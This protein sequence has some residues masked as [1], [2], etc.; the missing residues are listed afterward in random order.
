MILRMNR[1]K[2][3]S[4]LRTQ[5]LKSFHPITFLRI[6]D[7][8]GLESKVRL[9]VSSI[10]AAVSLSFLI[11][12]LYTGW[13]ELQIGFQNLNY[14]MLA[15]TLLAYPLGFLPLVGI[16]HRIMC[17][18]G[19]CCNFKINLRI[20]SLSCLP[21]R[22]P[23]TIWYIST[24][25]ALYHEYQIDYSI[26]ITATALEMVWL[27]LSG[28]LLYL[29]SVL[30]GAI[31][32][33]LKLTILSITSIV[34]T[35]AVL[36]WTPFR[37]RILRWIQQRNSLRKAMIKPGDAIAILSM[38]LFA[39]SGGGTLLYI[40]SN[41]VTNIPVAQLPGLIGAWSIA[42][43]VG[44]VAGFFV[45]GLGLREA[46]LAVV[47]SNYMPLPIAAAVSILFRM[48]LA[49]GEFVWAML[50]ALLVRPKV[51]PKSY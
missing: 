14:Q 35:S 45:Q 27:S 10:I 22:I 21:K 3:L 5:K 4:F 17:C 29:L 43:T 44:L 33:N 49:V 6:F 15:I 2:R 11:Y 40:L 12:I 37:H 26:T 1:T 9:I 30:M 48:L 46:T 24:R 25:V 34:L 8:R 36:L 32:P 18:I 38:C 31:N 39:W 28:F 19:G 16:W 41:A 13:L 23:G 50:F 20:Y 51:T 42:G 7:R 47:L